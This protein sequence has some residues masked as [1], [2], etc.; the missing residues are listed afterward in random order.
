MRATIFFTC[1]VVPL[2]RDRIAKLEMAMATYLAPEGAAYA[3]FTDQTAVSAQA[4]SSSAYNASADA[5]QFVWGLET[6][7][8]ADLADADGHVSDPVAADGLDA[9][10]SDRADRA[11]STGAGR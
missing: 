9:E 2:L 3:Y 7:H 5:E 4:D 1:C 8:V 6:Q 11:G 10:P